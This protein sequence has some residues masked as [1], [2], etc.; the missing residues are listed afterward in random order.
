MRGDAVR[1]FSQF[2]VRSWY[3]R[4]ILSL[5][6]LPLTVFYRLIIGVR[7]VAYQFG[8]LPQYEI[9]IPVVVVGNLTTGG[10]GKTPLVVKLVEMLVEEGFSPGIVSRGYRSR[11]SDFP[12][13]VD[14]TEAAALI[15]DEPLLLYEQTYRPV[16]ID[17]NRVRGSRKLRDRCQVDIILSDD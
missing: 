2:I 7:K 15:G 3:R 9:G 10:T 11:L 8:I 17:P 1:L 14:G 16:I 6:L 5:A 13:L 12:Y 4:G